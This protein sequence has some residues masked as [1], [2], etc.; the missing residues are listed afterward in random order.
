MSD[1][2]Q[3][4]SDFVRWEEHQPD[5][6]EFINGTVVERGGFVANQANIAANVLYSLKT[7]L[8]GAR[9]RAFGSGI[10]IQTPETG[11]L[12]YPAVSV[13]CGDYCPDAKDPEKPTVILD[14]VSASAAISD[15]E[16][17]CRDYGSLPTVSRYVVIRFDAVSVEVWGRTGDG[18]LLSLGEI[19]DL[20]SVI[21]LPEIGADIPMTDVY[22]GVK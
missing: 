14:V 6:H 18:S 16:Q 21:E 20:N 7:Q 11:N 9:C 12:R 2:F 17:R 1:G 8:K 22:D 5:R 4:L 15:L 13:D 10:R 19:A 3:T